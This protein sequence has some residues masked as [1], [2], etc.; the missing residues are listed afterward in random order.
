ME[1]NPIAALNRTF[2]LSKTNGKQEAI[3]EAEKLQ[4]TTNPYYFVLIGELYE[5]IDN[6]K[7]KQHFEKA[8]SLIKT[9]ADK[10]VISKRISG[11]N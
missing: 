2:A 7:A 4:L 3:I 5:G 1:I 8:L 11:L 10:T 9:N 6:K